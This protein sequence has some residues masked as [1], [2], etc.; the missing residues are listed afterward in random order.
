[1]ELYIHSPISLHG[2][3]LNKLIIGD[4]LTFYLYGGNFALNQSVIAQSV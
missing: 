1:M 3:M 2:V 4:N